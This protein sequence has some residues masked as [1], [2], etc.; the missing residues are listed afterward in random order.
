MTNG[1]RETARRPPSEHELDRV[2]PGAGGG[3]EVRVGAFVLLGVVAFMAVLFLLTD[4]ATFRGRYIV[5][6]QVEDAGGIRRGDPVQMRG[7]NIGR[8]HRFALEDGGVTISLE[9]EGQWEIPSDSR[10][11]LAGT[12]LLGGRT[13]E[14]IPGT[15]PQPLPAGGMMPGEAVSGI[16]DVAEDLGTEAQVALERVRALLDE[17]A[18]TALHASIRD[19]GELLAALTEVTRE[20]R[21]EL[22]RISSSVGRSADRVEDLVGN[23]S[24]DRSI[25]RAD[26]ALADLQI[27]G[28]NLA[29]ATES[30]DSIFGRIEAGEGTLGRLVNDQEL[31][32]RMNATLEEILLLARDIRENPGRYVNIGIF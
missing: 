9:I 6:T 18:V 20:Q 24:L 17:E 14:V 23:E 12:D 27:A 22:A 28:G 2:G 32:D 3:K 29:R 25:A 10:A 7:V 19:M 4:P 31:Y 30:M 1:A 8:V 16:M 21:A 5:L 11:R 26:S 15:S 13:V